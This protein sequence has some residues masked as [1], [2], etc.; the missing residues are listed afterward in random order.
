MVTSQTDFNSGNDSAQ[1]INKW[2]GFLL[3]KVN[4][5]VKW[6]VIR[7]FYDNP[8]TMETSDAIAAAI[9]ANPLSLANELEELSQAGILIRKQNETARVYCLSDE[10]QVFEVIQEFVRSCHDRTFRLSV[11]QFMFG[12]SDYIKRAK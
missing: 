6:D 11:I 3:E 8:H 7:F 10:P 4:S 1:F 5:F 12:T 9:A 2:Q